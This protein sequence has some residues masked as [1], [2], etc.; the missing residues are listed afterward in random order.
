[1][2]VPDD[3]GALKRGAASLRVG[4]A[5]EHFFAALHADVEAVVTEALSVLSRLTAGMQDV[6]VPVSPEVNATVMPAEAHAF[7][8]LRV[9]QHPAMFQPARVGTP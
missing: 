1:M 6:V 5:R 7:H 3:V 8:A 2:P 4:V 9:A